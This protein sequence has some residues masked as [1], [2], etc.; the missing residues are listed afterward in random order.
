MR[1]AG[2]LA[3]AL[4]ACRASLALA[5]EAA[6][7]SPDRYGAEVARRILGRGGNA[8]DAAVAM[9][10]SLSVTYPEA[11]NLGGGGFATV[12][13]EGQPSHQP[14]IHPRLGVSVGLR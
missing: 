12:L 2:W 7:A 14:F 13:F 5:G 6:V 3:L 10:F 11:G 8:I 4:L 9:A 1:R